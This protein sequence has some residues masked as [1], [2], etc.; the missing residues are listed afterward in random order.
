MHLNLLTLALNCTRPA[1]VCFLFQ[2][3]VILDLLVDRIRLDLTSPSTQ[4]L[5]FPPLLSFLPS[6]SISSFHCLLSPSRAH[7]HPH[8]NIYFLHAQ[9]VRTVYLAAKRHTH[10]YSP[11][12]QFIRPLR[13]Y[14]CILRF[15][16]LL[17]TVL[18]FFSLTKTLSTLIAALA[19]LAGKAF[20]WCDHEH[21]QP[22]DST[23]LTFH[24]P[25]STIYFP[26]TRR[27]ESPQWAFR[28]ENLGGHFRSTRAFT[29][30]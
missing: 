21:L 20:P 16:S 1:T 25:P 4:F 7:P 2:P 3:P 26:T 14:S 17:R 24:S 18:S 15:I 10:P 8:T 27:S 5:S 6:L 19:G 9:A 28:K 30:P 29:W 22:H 12:T 23:L 11:Q 13:N